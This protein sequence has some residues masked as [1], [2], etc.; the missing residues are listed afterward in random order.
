MKV[1]HSFGLEG[2]V[3]MAYA[4]FF[5]CKKLAGVYSDTAIYSFK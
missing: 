3:S 4:L 5:I 2:H 1:G